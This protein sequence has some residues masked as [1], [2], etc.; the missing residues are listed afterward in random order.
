[1]LQSSHG[2]GCVFRSSICIF[3]RR[4]RVGAARLPI[5]GST[6]GE[7]LLVLSAAAAPDLLHKVLPTNRPI[8]KRMRRRLGTLNRSLRLSSAE[9]T[10]YLMD[11]SRWRARRFTLPTTPRSVFRGQAHALSS[12]IQ[13]CTPSGRRRSEMHMFSDGFIVISL[14]DISVMT[15]YAYIVLLLY[16]LISTYLALTIRIWQRAHLDHQ[17]LIASSDNRLVAHAH[18]SLSREWPGA[19]ILLASCRV[20]GRIT[21]SL[22]PR[23]RCLQPFSA[24]TMVLDSLPSVPGSAHCFSTA[25]NPQERAALAA[26]LA[27]VSTR[28]H[29]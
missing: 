11:A 19:G 9:C 3:V 5:N 12:T 24:D 13:Y 10:A 2:V 15:E 16:L 1:M 23:L 14:I 26:H 18:S 22:A 4:S 6:N 25:R 8:A 29:F 17:F 28:P 21:S 27:V 7:P 20:S